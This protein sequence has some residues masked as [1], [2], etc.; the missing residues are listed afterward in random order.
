MSACL[1]TSFGFSRPP[2][3]LGYPSC[4]L[5]GMGCCVR[6]RLVSALLSKPKWKKH[7]NFMCAFCN[8]LRSTVLFNLTLSIEDFWENKAANPRFVD[9]FYA[10]A[11][12]HHIDHHR[13]PNCWGGASVTGCTC[14]IL[15]PPI[16]WDKSVANHKIFFGIM[17]LLGGYILTHDI[18]IDRASQFNRSTAHDVAKVQRSSINRNELSM[19]SFS[20]F[21]G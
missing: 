2:S 15:S 11:T 18:W 14:H 9:V 20:Q 13:R 8:C 12:I 3:S 17:V 4:L 6:L 10:K 1:S 19:W 5:S 7:P 21:L 16:E